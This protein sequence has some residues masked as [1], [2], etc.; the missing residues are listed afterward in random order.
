[1]CA[2]SHL[3][4]QQLLGVSDSHLAELPDHS[5]VKVHSVVVQPLCDLMEAP[6]KQQFD[7]RVARGFSSLDRHRQ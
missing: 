4:E 7:L 3:S 6:R 5:G 1:M 2:T